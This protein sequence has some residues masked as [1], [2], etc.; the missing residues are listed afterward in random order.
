MIKYEKKNVWKVAEKIILL[1]IAPRPQMINAPQIINGRPLSVSPL[2]SFCNQFLHWWK[3][4]HN[5]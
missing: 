4:F 2:L 1:K 3:L 5:V